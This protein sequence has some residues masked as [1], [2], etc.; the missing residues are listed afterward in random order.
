[1]R[2]R[3]QFYTVA[4][5]GPSGY[6]SDAI[7]GPMFSP[8]TPFPAPGFPP[9][10]FGPMVALP[11]SPAPLPIAP[12]GT[13]YID[14]LSSGTE[15]GGA[16]VFSVAPGAM[17]LPG[18]RVATEALFGTAPS[19]TVPPGVPV[20]GMPMEQSGDL[21]YSRFNFVTGAPQPVFGF[22]A[23]AGPV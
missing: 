21:F 9:A 1:S 17:G 3:A 8:P 16:Y 4:P 2:V 22:P 5:G 6:V 12:P 23:V 20:G 7:Y 13:Y 19:Q 11:P 18:S 10:G 14:A 15:A